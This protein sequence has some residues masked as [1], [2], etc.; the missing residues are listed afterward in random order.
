MHLQKNVNKE[1]ALQAKSFYFRYSDLSLLRLYW[2]YLEHIRQKKIFV[3]D[4]VTASK[5]EIYG[6]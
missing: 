3:I 4:V 1:F 5:A 2:K 6:Q